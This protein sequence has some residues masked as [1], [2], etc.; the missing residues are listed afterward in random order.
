MNGWRKDYRQLD[1]QIKY[2]AVPDEAKR[3][4]NRKLGGVMY[5]L[6]AGALFT[7]MFW[8]SIFA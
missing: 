8:Y 4:G 2:D 1:R 5:E 3:V 6:L 7:F